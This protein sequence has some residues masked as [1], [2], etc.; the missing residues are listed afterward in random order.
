V[1]GRG[2]V[3]RRQSTPTAPG[4]LVLQAVVRP[5]HF[6]RTHPDPRA[7]PPTVVL[8]PSRARTEELQ[9]VGPET[10]RIPAVNGVAAGHQGSVDPDSE[11]AWP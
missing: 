5:D 6:G 1:A 10:H 11:V 7:D 4:E 3:S 2:V 8:D 9:Q